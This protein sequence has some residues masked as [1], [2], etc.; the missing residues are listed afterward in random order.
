M[1]LQFYIYISAIKETYMCK[2]AAK[3]PTYVNQLL[4]LSDGTRGIPH[5]YD[6]QG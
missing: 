1:A 2:S 6:P 4:T 5:F 3:K